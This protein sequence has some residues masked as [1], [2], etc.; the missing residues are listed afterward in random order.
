ME[1]QELISTLKNQHRILQSDLSSALEVNK[2]G[3]NI[4]LDLI[5]FKNDLLEH[6]KLENETFY[7]DYLDKKTKKGEEIENTKKFIKEMDDIAKV[8]MTFLE[9]YSSSESIN[10]YITEFN[11]ELPDIISTLNMRIETEEDGVYDIYLSM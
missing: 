11:K 2:R 3:E 8:V 1:P 5:K 9:K 6:L 4:I 10:K 7:T